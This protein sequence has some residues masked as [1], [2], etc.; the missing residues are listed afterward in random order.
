MALTL[1]AIDIVKEKYE[2]NEKR[3]YVCGDSGGG[4]ISS[5][6]AP[7]YPEI[8]KGAIYSIGCDFW[9]TVK[10]QGNYYYP[11]FLTRNPNIK[12]DFLNINKIKK[13][14]FVFLTGDFD[15]NMEQTKANYKAYLQN[16]IKNCAYI[17]VK[18]MGHSYPPFEYWLVAFAYLDGKDLKDAINEYERMVNVSFVEGSGKK[19]KWMQ[20]EAFM[21]LRLI[22]YKKFILSKKD[23]DILLGSWNGLLEIPGSSLTVVFRFKMTEDG[24]FVGFLDSPDQGGFNIPVPGIEMED[25]T[26]TIKVGNLHAEFK[27]K[28][29]GDAIVGELK[30]G[31]QPLPLTIKKGEI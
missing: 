20:D 3:I 21:S 6:V 23:K 5:M 16:G 13:N 17:Q 29:T 14:S 11:G 10:S 27:G 26:V 2:V 19:G 15:G 9:D 25:D 8:I 28:I 22:P 24:E 1:R 12:V 30:Q 18:D 31:P 4:R 7:L